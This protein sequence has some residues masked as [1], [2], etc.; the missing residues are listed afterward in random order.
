[1]SATNGVN[2]AHSQTFTYDAAG[3]IA[4]RRTGAGPTIAYAYPAAASPRPHAPTH[5][6]G[7]ARAYDADGNLTEGGGRL[8]VWNAGNF[9]A[10]ITQGSTVA[11]MVYGPDGARIGKLVKVGAAA[12]TRA[13]TLGDLEIGPDGRQSMQVTLRVLKQREAR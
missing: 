1:L 3:S 7:A 11:R 6:G 4:S 12:E 10:R 8:F 13:I 9:P 5:V 2:P